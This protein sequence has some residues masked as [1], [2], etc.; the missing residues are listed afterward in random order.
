MKKDNI[1]CSEK[2]LKKAQLDYTYCVSENYKNKCEMH[3]DNY[4]FK[5]D[6]MYS[7]MERCEDEK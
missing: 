6:E 7:F 5:N 3:A 2:L 4:I 1:S